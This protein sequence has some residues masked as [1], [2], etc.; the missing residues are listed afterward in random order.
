[1][2]VIFD[3]GNPFLKN[4]PMVAI[5]RVTVYRG[6]VPVETPDTVCKRAFF[7]IGNHR[8]YPLMS[9]AHEIMQ[10]GGTLDTLFG[11][12]NLEVYNPL[13]VIAPKV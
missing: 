11:F 1:M 10:T 7:R 4:L 6:G 3:S 2:S 13:E 12:S 5:A 9:D 8:S